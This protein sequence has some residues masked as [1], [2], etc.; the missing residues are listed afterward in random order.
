MDKIEDILEE[1]DADDEGLI[2]IADFVNF[3]IKSELKLGV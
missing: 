3:I 1:L 2:D